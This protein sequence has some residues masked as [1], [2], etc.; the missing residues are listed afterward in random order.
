MLAQL[1][2]S[3]F[4]NNETGP[5][6]FIQPQDQ[7]LSTTDTKDPPT[8]PFV[9]LRYVFSVVPF[10]SIHF[11]SIPFHFIPF[12]LVNDGL[13]ADHLGMQGRWLLTACWCWNQ[14]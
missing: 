9:F 6:F 12:P 3:N 8:E 13:L 5:T 1:T 14:T 2:H 11:H 10:V 7:Q 4:F